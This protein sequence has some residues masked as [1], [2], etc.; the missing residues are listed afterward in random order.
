MSIRAKVDRL[1]H[2]LNPSGLVQEWATFIR[3][4]DIVCGRLN[5][6]HKPL[7]EQELLAVAKDYARTGKKPGDV[8]A[9]M[10][11][12]VAREREVQDEDRHIGE[13]H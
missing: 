7:T 12:R 2:K 10:L 6:D 9:E 3:E 13:S 4:A 1:Y 8:F 11:I 5:P